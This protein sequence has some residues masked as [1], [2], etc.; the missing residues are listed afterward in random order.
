[1]SEHTRPEAGDIGFCKIK[2][3]GGKVARYGMAILDDACRYEHAYLVLDNDE[4][5]EAMPGGARIRPLN[6]RLG[7]GF[8]YARLPLDPWQISHLVEGA[9]DLQGTPYSFLDYLSLSAVHLGVPT[10]MLRKY[11]SDSGHMICSQ[12]VD[13]A[14]CNY[15]GYH[16]F[17]DGRLPQDVTP[18]D[19]FY[20][21]IELGE[22]W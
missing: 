14:L 12:L 5:I 4:V 20:R 13:F 15:A 16:L 7:T 21:S 9:R 1:M 8:A 6:G 3:A 17:D 22:V 2:G 10:P 18:G 19:L 11:I